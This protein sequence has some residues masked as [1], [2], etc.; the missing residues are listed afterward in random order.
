MRCCRYFKEFT[1]AYEFFVIYK[2]HLGANLFHL[3]LS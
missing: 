3:L 2:L 1:Q